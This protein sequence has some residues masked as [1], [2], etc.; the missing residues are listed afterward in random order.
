[1]AHYK[2]ALSPRGWGPDCYRTW[3]ALL[4]G[5]IPIVRRC[6][7]DMYLVRSDDVVDSGMKC[8]ITSPAGGELDKLYQDLPVLIIDNWEELTDEF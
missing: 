4:V 2:F 3:E 5:T 1:M 6:Q 8:T 7:F